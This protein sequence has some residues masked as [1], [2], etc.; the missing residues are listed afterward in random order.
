[1][2]NVA[3]TL[4]LTWTCSRFA[5]IGNATEMMNDIPIYTMP[6][7]IPILCPFRSSHA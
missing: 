5:A 6:S 3:K 4:G 1:M 2:I 7:E